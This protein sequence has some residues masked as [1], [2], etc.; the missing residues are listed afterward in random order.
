GMSVL[1]R[2]GNAADAAVA[3]GFV[4]QIVE[5]HL[6]GP[7]GEVP[8]LV[9]SETDR[10]LRVISGQGVAPEAATIEAVTGLGVD[11]MPGT[12]LLPATVPGAFGGWLRLLREWGTWSVADVLEPAIT[13]AERG[14]PVLPRVAA[15]IAGMA[16]EFRAEWPSSAEVWLPGNAVPAAG[17]RIR[18]P[19]LARTYRRAVTESEQAGGTRDQR[20]QAAHDAWYGGFVAEAIDAFCRTAEIKDSTGERHRGL[21]TGADLAGWQ[22][23]V[24]DPVTLDHGRYTIAKTGP[25]GQGPVMLQQLALLEAAGIA[26]V[27]P[28]SADWVHLITEASKL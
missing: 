24:E 3:A 25:W 2:G 28:G 14:S 13:L 12:G 26:D 22:P 6:N 16:E 4:L 23:R 11:L 27:E 1:E 8:I 7:G 15:T 20:I 19:L 5:P 21:L 17:T 18:N 9:W 10:S